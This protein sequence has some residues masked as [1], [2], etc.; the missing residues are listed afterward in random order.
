MSKKWNIAQTRGALVKGGYGHSSVY[1]QMTKL[2]YV[3]GGYHSYGSSDTVLVD[4]LYS[5]N[6]RNKAW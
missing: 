1:D 4:L 6:P 5:Y 3:F 2:I